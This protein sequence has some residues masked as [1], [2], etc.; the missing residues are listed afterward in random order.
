MS[1]LRRIA[2]L[3]RNLVNP[4]R[5]ERDLHDELQAAFESLV[6]DYVRAGMAADAARRTAVVEFGHV[7]AVKE[8]VRD[9][10]GG[11]SLTALDRDVRYA[12]R[13]L[14]R[15]PVFSAIAV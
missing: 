2:S 15:N 12:A 7:E 11:A 10:R 14:R 1:T 3:W 6:D 4:Q 8:R 5:V 13:L 9:V